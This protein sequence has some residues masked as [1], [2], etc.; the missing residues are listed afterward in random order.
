M[1]IQVHIRKEMFPSNTAR[2]D[3]TSM[4]SNIQD[5]DVK[6]NWQWDFDTYINEIQSHQ[7]KQDCLRAVKLE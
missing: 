1:H 4:Y 2:F 5:K 3:I 6:K 7:L